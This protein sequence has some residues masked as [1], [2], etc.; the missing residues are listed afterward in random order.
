MYTQNLKTLYI[1]KMESDVKKLYVCYLLASQ[2][3]TDKLEKRTDYK[4]LI[5][6]NFRLERIV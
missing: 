3:Q 5:K 1:E 4:D 6:D 2:P